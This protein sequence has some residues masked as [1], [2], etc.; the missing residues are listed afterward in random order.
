MEKSLEK[1]NERGLH[2]SRFK[3]FREP[4]ADICIPFLLP[5]CPQNHIIT[6]MGG[7]KDDTPPSPRDLKIIALEAELEEYKEKD[8]KT[9]QILNEFARKSRDLENEVCF[10]NESNNE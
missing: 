5:S 10:A 6:E 8:S 9:N 7:R 4:E 2:F 3:I 1:G